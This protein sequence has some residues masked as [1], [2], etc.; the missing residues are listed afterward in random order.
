MADLYTRYFANSRH[1]GFVEASSDAAGNIAWRRRIPSGENQQAEA[2][3][4]LSSGNVVVIDGM[5]EIFAFN[6]NGERLWH[7]PKRPGT[8]I[9][10]QNGLIYLFTQECSNFLEAVTLAGEIKI[11]GAPVPDVGEAAYVVIMEPTEDGLVAQVQYTDLPDFPT[12]EAL[13]YRVVNS[14]QSGVY[15]WSR[16]YPQQESPL[17]PFVCTQLRRLVTSLPGEALVFDLDT[18]EREPEPIARFP[19]PLGDKTV[20]LS[21]GGDGHIHWLGYDSQAV[22]LAVTDLDGEP[23]HQWNSEKITNLHRCNPII[24]TIVTPDRLY[25]VTP[26]NLLAIRDN[27]LEWNFESPRGEFRECTALADGTVLAT[28]WDTL[29]R[30]NDKGQI[31]FDEILDEPLV[32]PPVVDEKGLIYVAGAETLYA[33]R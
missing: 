26:R 25:V 4:L 10:L 31:M 22:Y 14:E 33:L 6:A 30:L 16:G 11:E 12:G 15:A 19:F 32:T 18:K 2:R 3:L 21:C 17:V 1:N 29:Y 5:R 13:V 9:A 28:T 24:P 27:Q 8:Q 7:R 23:I 20:W